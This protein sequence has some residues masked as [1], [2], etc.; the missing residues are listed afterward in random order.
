MKILFLCSNPRTEA[1]M[2]FRVLQFLG[3]LERAGHEVVV[4]SFF[5]EVRRNWGTRV[6]FG[7]ARRARDLAVALTADRIFVHRE[8]FPLS[9]NAYARAFRSDCPLVFDF[10]D[11]VHLAVGGWRGRLARPKSTGGLI[12]RADLVFAGNEYLAEYATKYSRHVRIV[13]TVVDTDRF[14]PRPRPPVAK[15][16]IG[17]VGSPST[18][19]YL[20][21]LLPILDDLGREHAF[22]L[23]V[24]GAGRPF[25]LSHVEVDNQP[26]TLEG[27]V[28]AFQ[29]LDIGVYPLLDD[30]WSRG[31]C[32][33]KAIQYMACGVP[34]VV[35][36]VGV[37][38]TI[39]RDGVDGFWARSESEWKDR[40]IALLRDPDLRARLVADGRAR[41]VA[42]YS[43]SALAPMWV[44]ALE[45][46]YEAGAGSGPLTA[47]ASGRPGA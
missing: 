5:D 9:L 8:A 47:I 29:D 23:R 40:L 46:P 39:V 2:R 7:F 14:E 20:E 43:V 18:A 33:F 42:H 19:R 16:V 38:S 45:L 10:D 41:A 11:A 27:E 3:P 44:H 34:F 13:P 35:A 37:V 26:W 1:S 12:S 28:S 22:T 36:P 21:A 6:A 31:K 17:W 25:E 30:A 24:V 15:P 4:S 32:G